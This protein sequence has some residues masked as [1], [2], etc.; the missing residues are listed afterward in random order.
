MCALIPRASIVE[1]LLLRVPLFP[2]SKAIL[3]PTFLTLAESLLPRE[4]LA[5]DSNSS[6]DLGLEVLDPDLDLDLKPLDLDLLLTTGDLDLDLPSK[7]LELDLEPDL[8]DLAP[9]PTTPDPFID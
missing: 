8:Q 1:T 9:G 2:E 3:S 7:L 4:T 6:L 5:G